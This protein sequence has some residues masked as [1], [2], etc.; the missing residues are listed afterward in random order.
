MD[1][2]FLALEIF[3]GARRK[4]LLTLRA[5]DV[6]FDGMS[7]KIHSKGGERVIPLNL[8]PRLFAAVTDA[9]RGRRGCDP[10]YGLPGMPRSWG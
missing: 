10:V 4:D 1:P 6:D 8:D 7:V 9:C 3:A 5:R 2:A